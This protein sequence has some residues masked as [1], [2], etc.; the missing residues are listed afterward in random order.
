[1]TATRYKLVGVGGIDIFYREAGLAGAPEILLLHGFPTAS[2]MFRDLIGVLGS[3][4]HVVAPD[5]PGFGR[6]EMPPRGFTYSFANL[7]TTMTSFAEVIGLSHF[8]IYVFDY[9]APV[10]LRMAVEHPERISAIISQNGNAY[11]EGLGSGWEPMKAYWQAPTEEFRNSLRAAFSPSATR[12]QYEE[13][14]CDL[15]LIS[16]DAQTLD[17]YYLARPGAHEP[18]LD[19][20][21]DYGDNVALYPVFQ[22]YFREHQPPILAIWGERDPYF[23]PAGAMAFGGDVP[24]AEI[25]FLPTGH[26]ALESHGDEIA[27]DIIDFMNRKVATTDRS[28]GPI[29][30]ANT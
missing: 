16:P 13:G 9:G 15:T 22:R 2:H 4:F 11:E 17:N 7:A 6:S 21:T 30:A 19:Y 25:K 27:A 1:M 18:Q 5:L 23:V 12:Y 8:A 10:G 20:F 14:V 29:Q 28:F 3:H 26:F 24:D